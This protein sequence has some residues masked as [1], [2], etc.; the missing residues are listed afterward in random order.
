MADSEV[1]EVGDQG[2]PMM[3]IYTGIEGLKL[4]FLI[5]RSMYEHA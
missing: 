3:Q 5:L 1:P 2:K 4:G